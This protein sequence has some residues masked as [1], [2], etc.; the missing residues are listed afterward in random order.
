MSKRYAKDGKIYSLPIALQKQ[1]E[2][3]DKEYSLNEETGETVETEIKTKKMVTVYTNNEKTILEA[4]YEV[5]TP[6]KRTL[7][8]LIMQSNNSINSQTDRKIL[9][10]FEYNGN[11]FYL[12][13]ENQ[14]NFKNLY[15]LR[16][17][18]EYPVM[19]KTATGFMQLNNS[20]EVETFY[21][22]GVKFIETCLEE[23]WQ[24]KAAAETEIRKKYQ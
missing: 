9:N 13:M 10:D 17:V 3:I 19:V 22:T 16:F 15:D 18:R 6:P 5:Y 12:T 2:F 8:S 7:E 23:G 20:T 4:G 24:K 1:M 14:F 11:K 21:L